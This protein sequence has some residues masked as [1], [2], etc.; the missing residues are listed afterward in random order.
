MIATYLIN[1]LPSRV[2]EGVTLVQ[3]MTTFYPSIPILA[4]LQSRIFGCPTFVHVHSPYRGKLDPRAI[5]CVF[6]GYAPNK[7]GYKCYHP[8]SRKVYISKDVTF[9]ETK[10]F[11]ASSQLQ[12]ESIQAE[13]LELPHFPLLQDF[14]LRE[15]DKDPMPTSLPKKNNEDR[16]FG[17]QYQRR[18]QEQVL[19][20]QQLQLS[21]PEVRTHT[22]DTFEDTLNETNLDDLHIALRKE[23]RFC[24][25]YPISQ[26][27]STEKL[28]M[29][30]QSFLSVIILL[31]SLHQY[32]KP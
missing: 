9:H 8:Q 18:Q 2:L 24:A 30:H 16:Y 20:E 15:N 23:K 11:F 7:K 19:V 3:L 17:K 1:R 25:K 21:E 6:I 12:G 32:K 22:C 4:G 29:Q 28:S 10:S 13:D 26:F 31:E 5:K 27:V 14:V